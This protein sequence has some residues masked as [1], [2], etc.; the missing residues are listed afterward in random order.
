MIVSLRFALWLLAALSLPQWAAAQQ[1]AP[2]T[3]E[4]T[5]VA[6]EA[7][8]GAAEADDDEP[9]PIAIAQEAADFLAAQEAYAFRWFV[10]YDEVLEG[11]EKLTFLKSGHNLMARGEGF[12]SHTE[13]GNTYRDYYYDGEVFTVA[14]PDQQFYASTL[15]DGGFEALI[16][17]VEAKTDAV[18]PLWS[19]MSP[20]LPTTFL[21]GVEGAAYLGTTLIAGH[22]AHHLAFSGYE[23]DWQ[24]WVSTDPEAPLPVMIVGTD[25]YTQGWPQYRAYLMDWDL[26]P[27][28]SVEMFRFAPTEDD[29]AVSF[30]Q[31]SA[32][33][34]ADGG[35]EAEADGGADAPAPA[36]AE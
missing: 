3:A 8:D 7:H 25:P 24:V 17:A 5:E 10:S 11:R 27:E 16:A 35:A 18:L 36:A 2:E 23:E 30:P 9:D 26:A 4:A 12:V 28:H 31:L 32:L 6:A 29:I 13:R 15:F 14:S 1:A 22:E 21:E 19:I 33:A 34:E 20:T